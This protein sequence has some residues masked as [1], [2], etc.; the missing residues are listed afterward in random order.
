MI[1]TIQALELCQ[2][3]LLQEDANEDAR[4]LKSYLIAYGLDK[5]VTD[6]PDGVKASYGVLV[7]AHG[8]RFLVDIDGNQV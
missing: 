3:V 5:K 6:L 8:L 2:R 4:S 1:N 7:V